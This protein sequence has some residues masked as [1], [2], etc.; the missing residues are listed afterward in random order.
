MKVIII[1]AASLFV[2]YI[3]LVILTNKSFKRNKIDLGILINL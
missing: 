2:Y 3:G 1:I